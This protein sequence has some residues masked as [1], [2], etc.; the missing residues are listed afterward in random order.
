MGR[1]AHLALRDLDALCSPDW[2]MECLQKDVTVPQAFRYSPSKL[3]ELRKTARK[4]AKK[5]SKFL[6]INPQS[7]LATQTKMEHDK[8][9]RINDAIVALQTFLDEHQG[10][11]NE[12]IELFADGEAFREWCLLKCEKF[13]KRHPDTAEAIL[14]KL[15]GLTCE[16]GELR[17]KLDQT[18][19][20]NSE[21]VHDVTSVKLVSKRK[22][23]KNLRHKLKS[24]R[25]SATGPSTDVSALLETAADSDEA[26]QKTAATKSPKPKQKKRENKSAYERMAISKFSVK[27]V[28][29]YTSEVK[30]VAWESQTHAWCVKRVG[31]TTKIE[32][33]MFPI[34]KHFNYEKEKDDIAK[35]NKAV[36]AALQ[37]ATGTI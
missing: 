25:K 32:K 34:N 21:H 8:Y 29:K 30:G 11:G 36:D 3:E 20:K 16:E 17:K 7:A 22:E 26:Q 35:Y 1:K 19:G 33:K 10:V 9:T 6:R 13:K 4:N 2:V 5:S 24:L 23:R 15:E 27:K 12:S 37:D 31:A 14:D 28:A 18:K